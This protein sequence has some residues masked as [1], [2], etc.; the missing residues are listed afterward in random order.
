MKGKTKK[1]LALIIS[2]MLLLISCGQTLTY[3]ATIY[4][5]GERF[6]GKRYYY[7]DSTTVWDYALN[8][9]DV[10]DYYCLKGGEPIGNDFKDSQGFGYTKDYTKKSIDSFTS[11]T[12]FE[13][14]TGVKLRSSIQY[15]T[16]SHKINSKL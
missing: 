14:T 11:V 1:I 3:A 16:S 6:D 8:N 4:L 9:S 13:N 2:L 5:R 15:N 12:D 10:G 7:G